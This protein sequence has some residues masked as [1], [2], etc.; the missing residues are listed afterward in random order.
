MT[1]GAGAE[2]S[3][4]GS[5]VTTIIQKFILVSLA[6]T[7]TPHSPRLAYGAMVPS[8]FMHSTTYLTSHCLC[9]RKVFPVVGT[10]CALPTCQG[11]R[12]L[13]LECHWMAWSLSGRLDTIELA[14]PLCR[15]QPRHRYWSGLLAR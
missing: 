9:S 14:L 5:H 2:S 8:H 15:C 11:I 1:L 3:Q 4:S 10:I 7:A 6:S 12:S 13:F